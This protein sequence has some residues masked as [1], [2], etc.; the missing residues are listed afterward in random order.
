MFTLLGQGMTGVAGTFLPFEDVIGFKVVDRYGVPVENA[1]VNFR[2]VVGGGRIERGDTQTDIY[3]IAAAIPVLGG[4]IG[5]QEFEGLVG[6]LS[7]PFFLTA[8]Q[9]PAIQTGGVVNAASFRAPGANQGLAP[10]SLITIFGQALSDAMQAAGVVPLPLS[11][12]GV[13]IS[14]DVPERNLSVP[15]RVLFVSPGQVNVQV[16]WELHGLN[17]ALMKVSIGDI[18]TSLYTVPLAPHSPAF[19]EISDPASTRRIVAA[20]DAGNALITEASAAQRGQIIQL[21]GNGF[22]P[23]NNP[24]ATG[25]PV[26]TAQSTTTQTPTV[27]IGGQ[28]APVHFSGLAP[29]FV[30]L[31]QVNVEVPQG[32]GTGLQDLVIRI[33]GVDSPPVRIPIR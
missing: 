29:N 20:L 17:S 4:Q 5:E 15:A 16:P 27:T 32:I 1:P 24:P 33:G 14:F 23:V 6:G 12:S 2:P 21:F 25:E 30:G 9:R 8:R 26:A 31:Y 10:G 3:G 13:S 22:G 7:I 28:P 11:L 18:S 19:F